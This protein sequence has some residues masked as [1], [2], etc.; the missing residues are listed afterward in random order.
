MA[1]LSRV[2]KLQLAYN[3]R[4][5]HK[6]WNI[7]YVFGVAIVVLVLCLDVDWKARKK[8]ALKGGIFSSCRNHFV[9]YFSLFVNW[10]IYQAVGVKPWTYR[11]FCDGKWIIIP[12]FFGDVKNSRH[13]RSYPSGQT[14]EKN[15]KS[16][17][18][19]SFIF[20]PLLKKQ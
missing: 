13:K 14:A 5:F 16:N 18:K 19:T 8:W 4:P 20:S 11:V 10:K 1:S 7:T 17:F 2:S 6:Y 12:G 3:V 15:K 9:N